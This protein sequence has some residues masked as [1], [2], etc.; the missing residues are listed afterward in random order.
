MNRLYRSESDRILGGVCGGLAQYFDVDPLV[1]R[2]V[3]VLLAMINGLGLLAY[4]I[5]WVL[6]PTESATAKSQ[7]R[8]VRDNVQEISK[9][10]RDLGRDMHS[11]WG[12]H[13]WS[14]ANSHGKGMLLVGGGLVLVGLLIL[15]DN[16][17]LLWWFSLGTLW[18]LIPIAIGSVMLLNNLKDAR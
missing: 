7:D 18:P 8:I 1:T 12:E 15:L 2:I 3:F 9:R 13:G 6:V 11:T 10:A 16:L 4:L 14:T 17:G 5:V